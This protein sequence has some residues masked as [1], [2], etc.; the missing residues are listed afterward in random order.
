VIRL[1]AFVLGTAVLCILSRFASDPAWDVPC[2]LLMATAAYFTAPRA[3]GTWLQRRVTVR[4]VLYWTGTIGIFDVYQAVRTNELH[5][6]WTV[7]HA[8]GSSVLFLALGVV[9]HAADDLRRLWL[10]ATGAAT[11][12]AAALLAW[13]WP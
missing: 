13:S 5:L 7:G 8:A 4:S 10:P 2:S 1:A 9:L 11:V 6:D 3:V 12:G